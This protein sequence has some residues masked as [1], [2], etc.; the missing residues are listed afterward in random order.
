MTAII[1]R[2]EACE[3]G[4]KY[5]FTGKP[6]RFGHIAPRY[7]TRQCKECTRQHTKT[8]LIRIKS[9]ETL[10]QKKRESQHLYENTERYKIKRQEYNKTRAPINRK[11]NRDKLNAR[12]AKRR[13]A[14]LLRT[15]KWLIGHDFAEM[16]IFYSEALHLTKTTG[17][18]Y[19]VDHI[20][21]LQRED[22]CGLHVPWNL[23]ILTETENSAKGNRII[24]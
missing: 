19:T 18:K 22:V 3:R 9:N 14:K 15:P 8:R 16:Q 12:Q 24:G 23:Q 1:S 4:L 2:E 7:I 11:N 5:F 20:V 13:C 6:C 17:I 10:L 21:P